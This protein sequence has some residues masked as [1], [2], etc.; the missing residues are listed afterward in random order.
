MSTHK[1]AF[2]LPT[3][4]HDRAITLADKIK[5]ADAPSKFSN[6]L[7]DL[8]IE[9][10]D[11]GVDF[12]FYNSLDYIG[13]NMLLRKTVK[14]TMSSAKKPIY[15]VLRKVVKSLNDKQVV[16]VI[17]YMEMILLTVED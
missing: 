16:R 12:Y 5:N 6:E 11:V 7:A 3:A 2:P 9:I 17:E 15:S 14:V 4:L 1:V 13:V 8:I 10:S